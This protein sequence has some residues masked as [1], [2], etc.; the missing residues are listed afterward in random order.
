M[1]ILCAVQRWSRRVATMLPWLVLP[2]IL[3]WALSQLLPAAY[4]FEVTSPRLACVSVLLLTLFWYEILLPRLSVWRARRSARLREERRAHALELQKLRKT[5]TRRCRNCNN[6]YRDQNP[7]G[8]KFMCSY[9]GHVSKRPVL[10]LGPA[11]KVPSGW[12][13]SQDWVNAAGDPGYW[14][15]LRCSADNSYSGFSWR[16]LSC[17]CMGTT[18]FWRKVLRFG[19]SGDGRGLGRDGKMLGKGG[20]NGGKAEE[21][22]VDKAKRKA[23]EKRLARL[24]R[25]MLEEEERKQREEM[26]K[27]VEERRRLRDEKAEAEERSKG[28]TPVGEKDPRKEAERRRQERRRKEDKGSSKSN[29]DCEDIERRVNREGECKR[30]FDRR[31]EPDRRDAT[32]IGTEGY[33]SHNFDANNQGSKIVQS[34]TKYFGRMTGGLLSSSRSFGGGSIFGRRAQAPAPQANKVTKPLVAAIDQSNAVKRDAQPAAAQA[35]FK[36]ATTGE[37]RNSWANSHRSVSPNM[38]A[39]PT[40]LKKSWHQLFSRSASVSPCPDVTTSAR[41]KNGLPEFNGPQISSARNFLAQ[42][43]PLDSKPRLSQSMRFTG[44]PPVNG[45]PAGTPLSHFPAA[46]TPFYTEAEPTVLEEP[47]RFEDP[48][49]DPDAIALLGP[50]S[51]SLD[52]FPLD[53]DN[54]FVLSDVPKEPHVKPSPIESPLSRSRTVDEKPIKH[55]HLSISNGPN[56]ST[57]PDAT[58]EQG[59]WQMWST[60][61]VQ[62]SLGLRGPQTQWLLPNKNQFT[63]CV[64]NLNVGIRSPLSAGLHG[65]DIWLQKSPFQQLPLD[66]EN[67]FLSHD[68]SESDL[69]N[70]L[71]FGSPNKA[72]RLHPFVP[73]GPGHSWSKEELVLNGPPGATQIRSPKGVHAGLFP[74][75]PNVQSVW[76]FD[77]KRDNIELIN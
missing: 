72:A 18:W 40:G 20:E 68:L 53:W 64:D 23:E 21:S 48:C 32:R 14:L 1:C 61:L 15:D 7:G 51:E 42:Y 54:R 13:C 71:G 65:N 29:S 28:A 44:F 36:S 22:R 66:S 69:Q 75:N 67:M 59:T 9:C 17:F 41:E 50:V 24:E 52:S 47:E 35:M 57:S 37:T 77:Q 55:S 73:P 8:G 10:D 34:R 60:P 25:E 26:A 33:K 6:P 19:S 56:G 11:G 74:T 16:L 30:D 63:H 62:D 43:P 39:H 45:A 3:L 2:L 12:P 49:Y 38:Q 70:D 31:N 5:A 4:R 46:H 27:L 58:N 76:S